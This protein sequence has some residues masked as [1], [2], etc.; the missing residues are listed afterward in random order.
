MIN[1]HVAYQLSGEHKPLIL[2]YYQLKMLYDIV[3]VCVTERSTA[4]SL[5]ERPIRV[6]SIFTCHP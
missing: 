2:A 3:A 1:D 6:F 4:H 5:V